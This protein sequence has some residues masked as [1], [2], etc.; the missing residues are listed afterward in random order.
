MQFIS[1]ISNF[2]SMFRF[3]SVVLMISSA[4]FA[5][6]KTKIIQ[7]SHKNLVIHV[8]T[9]PVTTADLYPSTLLI[10]LPSLKLPKTQIRYYRKSP[11][12]FPGFNKQN[13]T[14]FEWYNLQILQNLPSAVLEIDPKTKD[15]SFYEIVEIHI[16]FG[17]YEYPLR[18]PTS[19]E[20]TLSANR[21]LNWQTA[22]NWLRPEKRSAKKIQSFPPGK[23]I[24][25]ELLEDGMKM[26]MQ[27][28]LANIIPSIS[29]HDPRAYMLFMSSELGRS[30]SQSVNLP[31][32]DNLVE[33]SIDIEGE[34]DGSFDIEDR[35]IF[36]GRGPSGYELKISDV[37][38]NQNLYFTTNTCWLF[39]PDDNSIRGK[40]VKMLPVPEFTSLTLDYGLSFYHAEIDL[41]NPEGSGLQWVGN[42]IPASG[43]QIITAITPNPKSGVDANITIQFMGNSSSETSSANHRMELRHNSSGGIQVGNTLTWTGTGLRNISGTIPGSELNSGNNAFYIQNISDD[44]NSAPYFDFFDIQYGRLL[45]DVEAFEFFAPAVGQE[46]RFTFSEPISSTTRVWDITNP[47]KASLANV[48][49][50]VNLEVILPTDT[51][52][53][54]AVFNINSLTN[55][56]NLEYQP[57]TVMD[58]L[59]NQ[60]TI[61]QYIIVGPKSFQTAVHP[62]LNLRNPSRYANLENIYQEYS[63]GNR[64]PMAVRSFLQW[65]QE[66]WQEPKPICVLL[67][68]D[69]GYDYRN[70]TGESSIIVPT[71][72][73]QAYRSFA[74]DDRFATIYGN[75]PEIAL[76]RYPARNLDEVEDFV[77]KIIALESG[78][79]FGPWRQKV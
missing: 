70:I 24:S 12:P 25:F 42:S 52:A 2:Y 26:I 5:S 40:R 13:Q 69:S 47:Q 21:I 78:P 10:G 1:P 4:L 56:E 6:V 77:D 36:Y 74:T 37:N 31:I 71:I 23:W 28:T 14:D 27:E 79:E 73:V 11:N 59:R 50:L 55:V 7:S 62:L 15:G 53:R 16:Q 20:I 66:N 22:K 64:D 60:I 8:V 76:G 44:G 75:I 9:N 17:P 29:S 3:V 34:S 43:S 67:L 65:T 49:N 46:V 32:A 63:A 35:I 61:A 18:R 33:V 57:N 39:L 45:D 41:V 72:Q 68:G 54:F 30:R 58:D 19:T 38:W 48:S 51:L